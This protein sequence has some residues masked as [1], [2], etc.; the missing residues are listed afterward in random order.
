MVVTVSG[1]PLG[2]V[3]LADTKGRCRQVE[4]RLVP[5]VEGAEE[6]G[7]EDHLECPELGAAGP[8]NPVILEP[9]IEY[10]VVE[11]GGMDGRESNP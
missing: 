5:S 9:A 11:L 1:S 8:E 10:P 4:A 2:S 3:R 6:P 7:R